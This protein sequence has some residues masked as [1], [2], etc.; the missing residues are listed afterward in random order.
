MHSSRGSYLAF[1]KHGPF[2]RITWVDLQYILESMYVI[3][4]QMAIVM[5]Q[6]IPQIFPIDNAASSNCLDNAVELRKPII[7]MGQKPRLPSPESGRVA[8]AICNSVRY[9]Q[10]TSNLLTIYTMKAA[11]LDRGFWQSKE[12]PEAFTVTFSVYD[13]RLWTRTSLLPLA[14]QKPAL[15]MSQYDIRR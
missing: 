5:Y 10:R 4:T 1:I 6:V 14:T 12:S 13:L 11:S 7:P 9:F 2:C 8:A 3:F 15:W